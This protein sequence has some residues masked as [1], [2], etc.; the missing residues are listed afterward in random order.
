MY[1][2]KSYLDKLSEFQDRKSEE[3]SLGLL[4]L[5]RDLFSEEVEELQREYSKAMIE[6]SLKGRVSE[7]TKENLLKETCDVLY[8]LFGTCLAFKALNQVELAFNRVHESNLSKLKDAPKD[9]QGKIL[10]GPN[11]KPPTL[12]DLL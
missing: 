3:F 1:Y 9:H 2:H 8:V 7:T 11:Y 5:R 12:K 4:A 10:K 6:L